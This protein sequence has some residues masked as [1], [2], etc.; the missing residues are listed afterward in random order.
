MSKRIIDLPT[1]SL[2]PT[3]L[4]FIGDP[5]S[6][7]LSQVTYAA[8]KAFFQ[9]TGS[10]QVSG[11]G[12]NG[13]LPL[14]NSAQF[15]TSSRIFQTGSNIRISG[16]LIDVSGSTGLPGQSLTSVSGGFLWSSLAIS[17]SYNTNI[18]GVN[19]FI[20]VFSGSN[21]LVTSSI[22]QTT[23][24]TILIS[25]S[26][27]GSQSGS[28][29]IISGSW[30][31]SSSGSGILMNIST[32][33]AVRS[34]STL[35]DLREN[36]ISRFR[37]FKSGPIVDFTGVGIK[38]G[39][40]AGSAGGISINGGSPQ[41]NTLGIGQGF[42]ISNPGGVNSANN[43]SIMTLA[44]G[45]NL[46]P[47]D[48]GSLSLFSITA[49]YAPTNIGTGSLNLINLLA[50]ISQSSAGSN[51]AR[52]LYINPTLSG[53]IDFRAIEITTGRSI[54]SGS[55]AV[56]GSVT[57][58]VSVAAPSSLMDFI[59]V[60]TNNFRRLV[61]G[62]IQMWADNTGTDG[63]TFQYQSS[64][65]AA[66]VGGVNNFINI[67]P[68]F[69]PITGSATW[70][71]LALNPNISQSIATGTTRG[72]FI[73]PTLTG[74][75]DFRAIEVTTG[76]SIF[77]DQVIH[78]GSIVGSSSSS[79][80]S[81][82]TVWNTTGAPTAFFMNV[83]NT[84][85][86]ASANIVDIQKSGSSV[87]KIPVNSTSMIFSATGIQVISAG[88]TGGG[89]SFTGAPGA[90]NVMN[91]N[92]GFTITNPNNIS[93][94]FLLGVIGGP[95]GNANPGVNTS[96]SNQTLIISQSFT[97][98]SGSGTFSTLQLLPTINQ[99]SGALGIT[100]G[101]HISP[102]LPNAVDFRAIEV[103]LGK[104]L[105]APSTTTY[106][107]FNIPSG[108]APTSPKDGDMWY[109]G[110]SGSFKMQINGATKTFTLL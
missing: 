84:A 104:T 72:L 89:I 39:S 8:I 57:A 98:L 38:V 77:N 100:R 12:L 9:S 36:Q 102:A 56:S 7:S 48:S 88:G 23:P 4:T 63:F 28:I 2:S 18:I 65:T 79:S 108:S 85:S 20:P 5:T 94:G 46:T 74:S 16:S 81:I 45:T 31:T 25:N 82:N 10:G 1:G 53:S 27:T 54:F 49:N 14:W 29:L 34:D 73:N 61:P 42:L 13:F 3:S 33:A 22:Q 41:S 107:S 78:T 24:S 66:Y 11:S 87:F 17:S 62:T 19:N 67:N 92:G 110:V 90:S 99:L 106:A 105:L 50:T 59:G 32:T 96:G 21:T 52:G 68:A 55:V 40:N 69:Q 70:N 58:S 75:V 83:V 26:I 64:T 43:S 30:D 109:D 51:I 86:S 93:S 97:P 91:I 95:A 101:L 47:S 35:I 71:V 37:I 60:A 44:A 103:T 80:I 6:G 15:L 76:K